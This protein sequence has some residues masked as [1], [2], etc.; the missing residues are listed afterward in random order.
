M[1]RTT[2]TGGAAFVL[3]PTVDPAL[4]RSLERVE[5]EGLDLGPGLDHLA[6]CLDEAVPE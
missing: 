4:L 1:L 3:S 6:D 2:A 5:R